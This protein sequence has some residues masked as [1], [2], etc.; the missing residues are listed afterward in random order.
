M[1]IVI[2]YDGSEQSRDAL[3]LGREMADLLDAT[4]VVTTVLRW[5][6]NFMSNDDLNAAAK[7]ETAELFAFASEYL[8]GYSPEEWW[9]I[10]RSP[11][12]ALYMVAEDE[13]AALIVVGS[14]H[15]GPVGRVMLGGVGTALLHGAPCAVLVAPRAFAERE[16]GSLRRIGVGF[17][18]SPESWA[19]LETGI[20]L[21]ERLD[22]A[23]KIFTVAEIPR[24]GYATSLSVFTAQEYGEFENAEK[25]GILDLAMNRVP[26]AV[27]AEPRLLT[28][29]AGSMLVEAAEE[30]DLIVMGSRGFGP[31][32]RTLLGSASTGLIRSS[33]C[34]ALVLP[35][36]VGVDPLRVR[37]RPR[38]P[39]VAADT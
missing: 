13:K 25:R 38:A 20:G 31:L 4:P 2:G 27:E 39:R 6:D 26:S 14:S 17:D 18:G 34:P 11:A 16:E 8:A 21:A 24:H 12:D 23:L 10:N 19:A 22:A 32:R 7:R 29:E 15:R 5:P 3:A 9:S 28:G 1:K 33:P 37:G 30:V 36:G 35:R